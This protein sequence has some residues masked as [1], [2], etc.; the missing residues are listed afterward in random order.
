MNLS[1]VRRRQAQNR[2]S[3]AS[4]SAAYSSSI[5]AQPDERWRRGC[6]DSVGELHP[7]GARTPNSAARLACTSPEA[8]AQAWFS[9]RLSSYTLRGTAS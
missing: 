7:C 6:L 5:T 2:S 4:V 3:V 8:V 9:L 1:M